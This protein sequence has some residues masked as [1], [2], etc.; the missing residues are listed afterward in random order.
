MS[1]WTSKTALA[2]ALFAT[3]ACEAELSDVREPAVQRQ[4]QLSGGFVVSGVRGW[5]VDEAITRAKPGP[6]V[7]V[8]GSCAALASNPLLSKPS[9]EA[10]LTIS[11]EAQSVDVPPLDSLAAFLSTTDGRA[12]LARDGRA[13]SL[14]LLEINTR[15]DAV[16]LHA[17]DTSDGGVLT[18]ED[19]WRA[20]FDIDG[21]FVTVSLVTP[22]DRPISRAQGLATLAAQVNQLKSAN[23]NE[24][25]P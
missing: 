18:G 24:R 9:V 8:L 11:V 23:P 16:I 17:L 4:V 19:H 20:L 1:T 22:E 3:A 10:V 14:D 2:V 25:Q 5:C 21:R 12:L 13:E 6:T 15:N 7:V